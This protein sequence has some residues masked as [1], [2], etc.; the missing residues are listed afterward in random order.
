LGIESPYKDD[1]KKCAHANVKLECKLSVLHHFLDILVFWGTLKFVKSR[2]PK[3]DV[4]VCPQLYLMQLQGHCHSAQLGFPGL[5]SHG[6][7]K[8]SQAPAI[9]LENINTTQIGSC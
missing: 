5:Q 1:F 9:L 4:F 2:Q 8:L 7:A 6:S 3:F